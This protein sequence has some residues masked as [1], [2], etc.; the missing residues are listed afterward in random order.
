MKITLANLHEATAQQVFDQVAAH[1][2]A[3]NKHSEMNTASV[4]QTPR[5]A[6]RGDGGLM[7]AA[8]CLIADEEY[9]SDNFEMMSWFALVQRAL[10]PNAHVDLICALQR[11]HDGNSTHEW[12]QRLLRVAEKFDLKTYAVV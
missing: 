6:Y 3:Q 2:L 1:L 10:V 12:H 11:V 4:I 9:N 8:G 5:C 7:C